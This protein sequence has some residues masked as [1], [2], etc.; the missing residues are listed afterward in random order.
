MASHLTHSQSQRLFIAYTALC[1]LASCY[2]SHYFFLKMCS[3]CLR[4]TSLS[5]VL[6]TYWPLT[7]FRELHLWFSLPRTLFPLIPMANSLIFIKSVFRFY[8]LHEI[9]LISLFKSISFHWCSLIPF[10]VHL[11]FYI[12][13]ITIYHTVHLIFICSVSVFL[14]R[15]INSVRE[16]IFITFFNS[17]LET[18]VLLS[19]SG[20]KYVLN[21]YLLNKFP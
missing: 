11:Y 3:F 20:I 17:L 14:T 1:D 5:C 10:S 6:L 8:R 4:H 16:I 12:V 21:K 18:S 7:C 9:F 15:N 13:L 2:L 19:L